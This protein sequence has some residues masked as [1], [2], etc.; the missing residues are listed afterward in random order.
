MLLGYKTTN[1]LVSLTLCRLRIL[2]DEM[3]P[4]PA[5]A[6]QLVV[7]GLSPPGGA[8]QWPEAAYQHATALYTSVVHLAKVKVCAPAPLCGLGIFFIV[9]YNFVK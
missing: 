3:L 5:M 7:A 2:P 4:L 6:T 1:K 9:N 8:V